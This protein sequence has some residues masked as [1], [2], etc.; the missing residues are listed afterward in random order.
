MRNEGDDAA[1]THA[2]AAGPGGKTARAGAVSDAFFHD[3]NRCR[4][5]IRNDGAPLLAGVKLQQQ[6]QN[7]WE[8][9]GD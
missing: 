8:R 1:K 9:N 2:K 6:C 7:G 3:C 4:T 5:E